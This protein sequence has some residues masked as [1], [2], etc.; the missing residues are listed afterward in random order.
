MASIVPYLPGQAAQQGTPLKER[1]SKMNLIDV[2]NDAVADKLE[3]DPQS[4]TL[5]EC[6]TH[7]VPPPAPQSPPPVYTCKEVAWVSDA[8]RGSPI[9]L[10]V[11]CLAIPL[12]P[13]PA[14]AP[15]R[16]CGRSPDSHSH[17]YHPTPIHP[18]L[19]LTP[20]RRRP[21]HCPSG[22]RAGDVLLL[23]QARQ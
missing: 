12:P 2:Y 7:Q 4:L 21:T 1:K 11:A 6:L 18:T 9:A 17:S 20:T 14:A 22:V 5:N 23:E 15:R 8:H 3:S 16:Y 19:P 13:P 10:P